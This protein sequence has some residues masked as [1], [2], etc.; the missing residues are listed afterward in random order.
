MRSVD[1]RLRGQ[2][3]AAL[4]AACAAAGRPHHPPPGGGPQPHLLHGH[5]QASTGTAPAWLLP[6]ARHLFDTALAHGWDAQ[7]GGI[8]YGFASGTEEATSTGALA[9][10]ARP[11]T[12][13]WAPATTCW[14]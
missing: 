14:R 12:T 7:H 6:T 10:P 3:R 2:R 5:L 8:V 11:T 13:P 9:R 1:R 4:P